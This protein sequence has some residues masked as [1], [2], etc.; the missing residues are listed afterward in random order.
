MNDWDPLDSLY[1]PYRS[2]LGSLSLQ[3]VGIV[4]GWSN[5]T[6]IIL[7]GNQSCFCGTSI[8]HQ[9]FFKKE[10]PELQTIKKHRFIKLENL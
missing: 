6:N 1:S 4:S 8:T 2:N 7:N 3:G 5:G 9:D 10:E